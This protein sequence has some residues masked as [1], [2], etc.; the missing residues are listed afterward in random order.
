MK[1]YSFKNTVM[2][3]AGV[4]ISGF[5]QGDDVVQG[6]RRVDAF[7]DEVGA[8]GNLLVLQNADESGQFTIR[9]QQSS[10]S[11]AYLNGLFQQQARGTFIAVPVTFKD[12][13]NG[14]II[15]GSK[16][17]ITKPADVTRGTGANTQEWVLVVEK[18]D[19]LFVTIPTL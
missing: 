19:A 7:S 18:Y 4:P 12:I 8:D 16:G 3:V 10:D 5:A 11:N 2:L 6:Q 14:E 13:V 15:G 9:L 17:Y 1:S